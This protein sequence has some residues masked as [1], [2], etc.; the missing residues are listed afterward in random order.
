LGLCIGASFWGIASDIIGRRLAFNATLFLTGAFA[1][2]LHSWLAT[3]TECF[4]HEDLPNP[5]GATGGSKT[6]LRYV[7][8]FQHLRS[9]LGSLYWCLVLGYRL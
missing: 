2:V 1:D 8:A 9:I 5:S 3:D 7:G 6:K 4:I